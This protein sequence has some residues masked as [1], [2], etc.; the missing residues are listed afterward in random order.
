MPDFQTVSPLLDGIT[1]GQSFSSRSGI[2]CYAAIDAAS[3]EKFILKHILVPESQVKIDA[4]LLAGACANEDDARVYFRQEADAIAEEVRILERLSRIRG[5]IPFRGCQV[6][7]CAEGAGSQVYL[8]S[9]YQTTLSSFTRKNAMTHLNAVNL[10]IDLCA[11]LSI[12]H[13]AGYLYLDLKPENIFMTPQ[14][15]FLIGDL[16]FLSLDEL[17][18]A[19]FPDKYQSPYTAPEV[20]DLM[21]GLNAT[22]DTYALGMVLYRIYNGGRGPFEDELS[23]AEADKRRLAGEA[24][25]SPVYADYEMAGILQKACAFRPEDRWQSPEEMGQALISYMQRNE[26]NDSIIAPPILTEPPKDRFMPDTPAAEAERTGAD[27]EAED[28]SAPGEEDVDLS[29]PAEGELAD[30]LTQADACIQQPVPEP[31]APAE[32]PA[33]EA[34]PADASLPEAEP[35]ADE[36]SV[37]EAAPISEEGPAPGT[38]AAPAGSASQTALPSGF[39]P[40]LQ[41]EAEDAVPQAA[42]AD[43]PESS[44]DEAT[45]QEE[46]GVHKAPRK[47]SV[48]IPVLIIALVLALLAVGGY[49][50]YRYYY[51]VYADFQMVSS[52]VDS[53]QVSVTTDADPALLFVTCTDTYGNSY[54]AAPENGIASFT[55]LNPGTQYTVV[56]SVK[57]FHKLVGSPNLNYTSPAQ[58]E[59][60]NFTGATGPEDGSV[61]LSFTVNGPEGKDWTV[62]Y[63]TEGEEEKQMTFTGH[64]VTITGLT[65]G[66]DYQFRLTAEDGIYLT[67]TETVSFTAQKV[68]LAQDLAITG[69]EGD[70]LTV[71]WAQPEQEVAQWEVRCYNDSGFDQ[72]QTVSSCSAHFE[73]LSQDS[74]Y[75]IEVTAENMCLGERTYLSAN[76]VVLSDLTAQATDAGS[77]SVSWEFSGKEPEGGWLVMYAY[78]ESDD[79]KQ[80]AQTDTNSLKLTKLIPNTTYTIQVQAASGDITVFGGALSVRTPEAPDF[81]NYRITPERISITAFPTPEKEDWTFRDINDDEKSTK[82]TAEQSISFALELTGRYSSSDDEILITCVVRSSNGLPVDYYTGT[83]QWH[84]MWTGAQYLGTLERTPQ[85]PGSYTL[86]IYFNNRLAKSMEF[87]IE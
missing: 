27:P 47:R 84:A 50:F 54:Q 34:A 79:A 74:A 49:F 61:I 87:T 63:S 38:E 64:L 18:F 40:A 75:Y 66:K 2:R 4:M 5:F 16:G 51:C 45:S 10:G 39:V 59:I 52:S 56:L 29:V 19:T 46:D 9:A 48:W 37:P 70:A 72:T 36:A 23:P 44:P 57:G 6:E 30:I 62:L 67:G 15:Q 33:P 58:T 42:P 85:E 17:D 12:C 3:G 86:E 28:D 68:L 20:A 69:Y 13:K 32:I 35:A 80:A 11:A 21:A 24:L 82:F 31:P 41:G 83:E 25:P 7:S 71:T 60:L 55:G 8:L 81:E 73:G 14:R 53:L 26:V 77:L 1:I 65:V 22:I 76:P 43:A 78:G